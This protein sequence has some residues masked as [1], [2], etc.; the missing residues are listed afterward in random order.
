[1]YPNQHLADKI[2]GRITEA[3]P[4]VETKKVETPT[5]EDVHYKLKEAAVD[6]VTA[7]PLTEINLRGEKTVVVPRD[8]KQNEEPKKESNWVK[9]MFSKE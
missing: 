9:K 8:L 6:D 4:T 5:A 2:A 1:M 7:P 3:E